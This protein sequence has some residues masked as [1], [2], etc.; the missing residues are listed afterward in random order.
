MDAR[1]CEFVDA[2]TGE[3]CQAAHAQP[4]T[5]CIEVLGVGAPITRISWFCPY[6][7]EEMLAEG[8]RRPIIPPARY[9]ERI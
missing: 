2:D 8:W 5:R 3:L 9:H 7:G 1:L 4:L 6:H